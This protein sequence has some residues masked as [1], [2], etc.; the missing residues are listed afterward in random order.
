MEMRVPSRED[1]K[2]L[3]PNSKGID[4]LC[5]E[6]EWVQKPLSAA[7]KKIYYFPVVVVAVVIVFGSW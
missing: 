3:G 4:W 5:G 7:S 2:K 1:Q 6:E